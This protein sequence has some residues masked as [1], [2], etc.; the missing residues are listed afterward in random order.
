[1]AL[2][3]P[4]EGRDANARSEEKPTLLRLEFTTFRRVLMAIPP[5]IVKTGRRIV[6]RLL[7]WNRWPP[8][9]LRLLD[10]LPVPIRCGPQSL[11][12]ESGCSGPHSTMKPPTTRR[13]RRQPNAGRSVCAVVNPPIQRPTCGLTSLV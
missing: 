9:F 7:A 13:R 12:P 8:T 11:K 3:L 2:L 4:T 1:M 6:F 10:Q 5:Q